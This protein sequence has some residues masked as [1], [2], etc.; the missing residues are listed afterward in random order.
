[1]TGDKSRFMKLKPKSG[2][3]VTFGDNCKG[4]IEDDIHTSHAC[5][6]AQNENNALLWHR[7]LGHASISVLE[8][9]VSQ[10]LVRDYLGKFDAKSDEAIFLGYS[11]NFI[12]YRVFNKRT[13]VV[14]KSIH[15]V[16]DENLLPR[17]DSCDDDN[18]GIIEAN[19]SGQ[20]SK[21]DEI[22]TKE[23]EAQDPPIESLKDMNLGEK[24]ASYPR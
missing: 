4:H 18:V 23:P 16:F 9:L 14:E 24:G 17:K 12:A 19:N 13:L 5:L 2:G 7:K 6:M 10:N 8:K 11:L 22:P 15:V 20:S 3:V 21:V 1:M